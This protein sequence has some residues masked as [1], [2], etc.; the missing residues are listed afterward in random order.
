MIDA[1]LPPVG[2]WLSSC[3]TAHGGRSLPLAVVPASR[4][5]PLVR[6]G[7]VGCSRPAVPLLGGAVSAWLLRLRARLTA[8]LMLCVKTARPRARSTALPASPDFAFTD[9][10]RHV[11][12]HR[13]PRG[14]SDGAESARFKDALKDLYAFAQAGAPRDKVGENG[15]ERTPLELPGEAELMVRALDPAVT[16]PRRAAA[17]VQASAADP[18]RAGGRASSR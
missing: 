8:P 17:L 4:A 10:R 18:R 6:C 15:P 1:V 14:G 12:T 13:A 2:R 3:G 16:I 5:G 7:R 9:A 11:G